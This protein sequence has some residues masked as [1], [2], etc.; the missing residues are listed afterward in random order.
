MRLA[1]A[2]LGVTVICCVQD[3]LLSIFDQLQD[4]IGLDARHLASALVG[5]T[6]IGLVVVGLGKAEGDLE[7]AVGLTNLPDKKETSA[8][9]RLKVE[10]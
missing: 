10:R 7:R 3:P 9:Q 2:T 8:Y 6:R 4:L 5:M 1:T